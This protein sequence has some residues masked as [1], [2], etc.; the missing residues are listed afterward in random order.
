MGWQAQ[1]A[2]VMLTSP[3]RD[4]Q[5]CQ[6]DQCRNPGQRAESRAMCDDDTTQ[7]RAER[8]A[9]IEGTDIQAGCEALRILGLVQHPQLQGWHGGERCN[10]EQAN[11]KHGKHFAV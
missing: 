7:P 5:A 1:F 6:R 2:A 9:K 3:Q 10:T 8:I 11:E 4:Q